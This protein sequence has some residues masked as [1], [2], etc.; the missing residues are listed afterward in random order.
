MGRGAQSVG[1]RMAGEMSRLYI[2][3]E[4]MA[5]VLILKK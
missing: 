1:A 5:V 2:M 4:R 3:P